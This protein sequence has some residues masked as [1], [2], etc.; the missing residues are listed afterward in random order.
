MGPIIGGAACAGT[1]CRVIG[2]IGVGIAIGF[3]VAMRRGIGI[4][5]IFIGIAVIIKRL[6]FRQ[7][8]I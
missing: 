7:V 3:T 2:S 5:A 1:G 4:I 6:Q 8:Q